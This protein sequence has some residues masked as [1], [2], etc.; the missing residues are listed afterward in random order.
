[1]RD[2]KEAQ[3]ENPLAC[4]E[5]RNPERRAIKYAIYCKQWF[6]W[7]C[8][9]NKDYWS[10]FEK[11]VLFQSFM[12]NSVCCFFVIICEIL[13]FLSA[14]WKYY[15]I[16]SVYCKYFIILFY[17]QI[18]TKMCQYISYLLV[19]CIFHVLELFKN[20]KDKNLVCFVRLDKE[21]I[22]IY[23]FSKK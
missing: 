19:W 1:M 5:S 23:F 21:K 4:D 13:P 6:I 9:L 12:F 3:L 17:L 14:N 10:M 22:H 20:L 18:L 2:M 16:F 15:D 8:R 7:S 11:K